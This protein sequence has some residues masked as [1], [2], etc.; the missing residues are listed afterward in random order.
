MYTLKTNA[1]VTAVHNEQR[2]GEVVMKPLDLSGLHAV[3]Y[4]DASFA[5]EVGQQSQSGF[6]HILTHSSVMSGF[7]PASLAEFPN[8]TISRVV[9]STMVAESASLSL[10]LDRH[11]CLRLLVEAILFDEPDLSVDWRHKLKT[12]WTVVTDAT[13][14]F[15][16][17]SATVSTPK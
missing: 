14:L 16:H 10:A 1:L 12:K 11:I 2:V 3:T 15:D 13:T 9:K 8:A 7:G 4:V 5:H 6:A 17:L